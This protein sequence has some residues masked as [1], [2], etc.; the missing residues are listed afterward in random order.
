MSGPRHE[1]LLAQLRREIR[2]TGLRATPY[3]VGLKV[4]QARLP[5]QSPYASERATRLFEAGVA[6]GFARAA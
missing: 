4:A 3:R 5:L 2:A 6:R 1:D